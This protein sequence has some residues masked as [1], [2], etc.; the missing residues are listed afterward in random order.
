MKNNFFNLC[1]IREFDESIFQ[2]QLAESLGIIRRCFLCSNYNHHTIRISD[3]D[4]SCSCRRFNCR[5]ERINH[6]CHKLFQAI[7]SREGENKNIFIITLGLTQDGQGSIQ[8]FA[9]YVTPIEPTFNFNLEPI[10]MTSFHDKFQFI[11]F[12]TE[13]FSL[14]N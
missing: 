12:R 2:C 11:N 10:L 8:I 7:E 4:D 1:G 13:N 14:E 5:T 3:C 6:Y 9:D